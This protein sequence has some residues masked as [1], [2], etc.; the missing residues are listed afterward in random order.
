MSSAIRFLALGAVRRGDDLLVQE[1]E[2]PKTGET[3][4]RVFGGG[5]EFGEHS[6]NA[7]VV[8]DASGGTRD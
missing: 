7:A 2:S 5:V 4:Y 8:L 3:F 6:Q 1:A